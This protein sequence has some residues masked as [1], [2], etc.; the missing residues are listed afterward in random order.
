MGSFKVGDA[1]KVYLMG[2]DQPIVGHVQSIT[3][4]I[5]DQNAAISTQ[6]LPSVQA[7]YTWVRLAQRIPV[8][9]EIETVPPAITLAAG[10]TAT[11]V[12]IAAGRRGT[13]RLGRYPPSGDGPV[14]PDVIRRVSA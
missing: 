14:W 5:S 12:V 2:Y 9:V 4:G 7:V 13:L 10:M 3:R 11:V 6:G 8:R 1:A